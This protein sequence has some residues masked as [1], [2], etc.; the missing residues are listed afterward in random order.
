MN[1]L[2]TLRGVEP[3]KILRTAIDK[4]ISAIM[5]YLS[6]G[7]WHVASVWL[8][9]LVG[10]RLHIESSVSKNKQRPINIKVNQPVGISFKYE[11]GK[12]VFDTT[13]EGLEPSIRPEAGRGR[14]GT[15]V[16]AVPD[17]I[18]VVQRRS[19][20]RVDVPESLNVKVLLWHRSG[21]R[22]T[23]NRMQDAA[24]GMRD[25]YLGKLAD[26]SAGG[27]QVVVPH[28]DAESVEFKK[29]QFVGM[30]FTPMPYETP[31]TLS[32]QVRNVLP[33]VDG[34]RTSL[35]L[36]IVG[37]E[38]SSEG[39]RVLTRLVAVV[40]QYYQ[41]NQSNINHPLPNAVAV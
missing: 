9:N 10:N 23:E 38:A 32:A 26:I 27:A 35:G 11:N 8:T 1:E 20:F 39:R 19:Y 16:L 18:E 21:R 33:T 5:S 12:F 28:Y 15:I 7:K 36:Q 13:V 14:G 41:M 17:R 25:C 4:K 2:V 6:K 29:G 37:L 24:N 34:Q 22:K 3:E 40:E 31:L 30:R